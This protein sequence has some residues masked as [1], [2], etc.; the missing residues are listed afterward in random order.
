[1]V[2][3]LMQIVSVAVWSGRRHRW[4]RSKIWENRLQRQDD[5]CLGL[6]SPWLAGVMSVLHRSADHSPSSILAHGPWCCCMIW[7]AATENAGVGLQVSAA[8]WYR[9]LLVGDTGVYCLAMQVSAAW[10]CRSWSAVVCCLVM[11]KPVLLAA[12]SSSSLCERC[13]LYH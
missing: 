13:W 12:A 4:R 1:M 6:F 7:S 9:C 8:W 11:S 3:C 10:W 2:R 5:R